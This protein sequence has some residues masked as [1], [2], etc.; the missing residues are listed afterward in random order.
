MRK[1]FGGLKAIEPAPSSRTLT[2]VPGKNPREA[3]L[4]D[5]TEELGNVSQLPGAAA[6]DRINGPSPTRNRSTVMRSIME[7]L[8][9]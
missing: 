5:K 8:T 4:V 1:D 9:F 6:A 7:A 2:R 3:A